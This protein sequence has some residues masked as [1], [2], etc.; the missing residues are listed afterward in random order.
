MGRVPAGLGSV[1]LKAS[2][3]PVT[4]LANSQTMAGRPGRKP[5]PTTCKLFP[6]EIQALGLDGAVASPW[7]EPNLP[8][9][10]GGRT[11]MLGKR[12][13]KGI[14]VQGVLGVRKS[15]KVVSRRWGQKGG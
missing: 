3:R 12:R 8:V 15:M 2:W 6:T 5:C 10:M 13:G 14:H 1:V 9:W 11:G 7:V 4:C